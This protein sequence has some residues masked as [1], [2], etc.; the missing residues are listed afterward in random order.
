MILGKTLPKVMEW[1]LIPLE[2]N[3]TG[4]VKIKVLIVINIT[5]LDT[6]FS[7]HNNDIIIVDNKDSSDE[8]RPP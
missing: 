8:H 3:Q 6:S 5:H 7:D 1:G 2:L 4:K